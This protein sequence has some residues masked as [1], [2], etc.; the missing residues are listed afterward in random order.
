ME[1]TDAPGP[2]TPEATPDSA[3][4][5][6]AQL[7]S[8]DERMAQLDER[9][10]HREAVIDR[11]HAENQELRAG[12]R[13]SVLDPVIADLI[14]LHEHLGDEARRLRGQD[15]DRTAALLESLADDALLALE[16]VGVMPL[17]A[18]PGD[19][20]RGD[21]HQPLSTVDA[22]DPAQADTVARVVSQGFRDAATGRVRRRVRAHF[23]RNAEPA[24]APRP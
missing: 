12:E 22:P 7:V 19:P 14:R 17:E 10:R 16:R 18:R 4:V 13:R 8:L 1:T 15:H 3:A 23:Y 2:E 24:T 11:L 9:A 5:V 6:A 20:F 21:L